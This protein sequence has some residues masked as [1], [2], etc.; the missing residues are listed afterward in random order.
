M[1]IFD[2]GVENLPNVYITKISLTRTAVKVTCLMKDNKEVKTWRHR[3]QMANMKVKA[4]L[5]H[6]L[7]ETPGVGASKFLTITSGL[8]SGQ[9]SLFNYEMPDETTFINSSNASEFG[10]RN[11]SRSTD[12]EYYYNTFIFRDSLDRPFVQNVNNMTVYVACFLDG[13]QFE[14]LVFNKYYGPAS[15]ENIIISNQV[16]QQSGYFYI[17]LTDKE[18]GGPV[19]SHNGVFMEG[20]QHRSAE[21]E[22][23][24]YVPEQN[25]KIT[26]DF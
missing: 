16:N 21:H 4:L 24:V 8:N 2:V 15:S 1:S 12:E 10:L 19:H 9:D 3:P 17:P 6:D 23:L 20:S 22:K 14:N 11:I 25:N 13:L 26:L 5:V 18:Y 7:S